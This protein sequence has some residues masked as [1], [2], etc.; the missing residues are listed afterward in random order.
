VVD[1]PVQDSTLHLAVNGTRIVWDIDTVPTGNPA[2]HGNI[3]NGLLGGY[4]LLGDAARALSAIDL[5]GTTI[6]E[7]TIRTILAGQADMDVVPEGFT[8]D[9]CTEATV[10]TDCAPGQT[11]ESDHGTFRCYEQPD[12]PDA[13]SLALVFTAVSCEITGI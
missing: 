4:I 11:C 13:I 3:K 1:I 9:A 12:N 6:D 8:A 10:Q 5:S 7:N 2:L